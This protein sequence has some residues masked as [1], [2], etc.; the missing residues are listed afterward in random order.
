MMRHATLT[1][2]NGANARIAGA[3]SASLRALCANPR[4]MVSAPRRGLNPGSVRPML[5]VDDIRVL[6]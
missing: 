3:K 6:R 2:D 1:D 4:G 5:K